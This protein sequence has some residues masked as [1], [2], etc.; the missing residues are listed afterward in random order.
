[1]RK[2]EEREET[3]GNL[4]SQRNFVAIA[5]CR[6]RKKKQ[7]GAVLRKK[8]KRVDATERAGRRG[9]VALTRGARSEGCGDYGGALKASKKNGRRK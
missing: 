6:Y 5:E 7:D 9:G 1:V 3:K 8:A 4:L 2:R